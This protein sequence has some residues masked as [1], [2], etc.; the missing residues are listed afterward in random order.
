MGA[1]PCF[2]RKVEL[3]VVKK[4]REIAHKINYPKLSS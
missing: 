1:K 4:K 2:Y 3:A